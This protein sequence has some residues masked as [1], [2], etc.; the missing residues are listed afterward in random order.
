M[1][2]GWKPTR[3][4]MHQI[5]DTW[6]WMQKITAMEVICPAAFRE[7]FPPCPR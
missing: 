6:N 2:L 4:L 7:P 5:E 3:E 1:T